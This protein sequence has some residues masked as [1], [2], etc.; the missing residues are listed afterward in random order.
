MRR[1]LRVVEVIALSCLDRKTF[2]NDMELEKRKSTIMP[3]EMFNHVQTYLFPYFYRGFR[4]CYSNPFYLFFKNL[5]ALK[6]FYAIILQ[7]MTVYCYERNELN[8]KIKH[9]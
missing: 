7:N 1:T 4:V 9:L 6:Y 3:K 2:S 8:E 5:L